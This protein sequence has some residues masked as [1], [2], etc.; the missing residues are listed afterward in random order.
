MSKNR[1]TMWAAVRVEQLDDGYEVVLEDEDELV[2]AHYDIGDCEACGD[3]HA[4]DEHAR[5]DAERYAAQVRG[6][7][8]RPVRR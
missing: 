2:L 3:L 7:L 5:E 4:A 8:R 1:T 6:V